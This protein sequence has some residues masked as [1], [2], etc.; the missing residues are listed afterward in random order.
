MN[1]K[2][3]SLVLFVILIPILFMILFM[4]YEVGRM[5]LLKHELNDINYLVIDCVLDKT[6]NENNTDDIKELINK[7]KSDIDNIEVKIE[8][9]KIY[10]TLEDSINTKVS[11]IKSSQIFKVKS[12]YVGYMKEDKK[13]IERVR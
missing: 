6:I 2:G 4:V 7:N 10:V 3:Q 13:A 1:N 12:S 5:A 11:L 9:E 8:D